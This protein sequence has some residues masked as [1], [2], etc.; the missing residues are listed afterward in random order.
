MDQGHWAEAF[1]RLC[2]TREKLRP[3]DS[4]EA[5]KRNLNKKP[6]EIADM[7]FGYGE[8]T[9]SKDAQD[10]IREFA[11]AL[12]PESGAYLQLSRGDQDVVRPRRK[13]TK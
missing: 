11:A 13:F 2:E 6:G 1:K 12:N 8:P 9:P 3:F 7:D 4:D 5:V 10:A